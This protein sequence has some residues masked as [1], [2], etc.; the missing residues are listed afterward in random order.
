M[1]LFCGGLL[2]FVVAANS[3]CL[4][5]RNFCDECSGC[6]V[7]H[8]G[9]CD[10]CGPRPIPNGPLEELRAMHRSL[11]CGGGCGEVYYGE[12]F[13]TPPNCCDPCDDSQ[14]WVGGDGC[15]CLPFVR[16]RGFLSGLLG[17]RYR[18][19]DTPGL[20][21][22]TCGICEIC[23]GEDSSAG[24][25]FAG[26]SPGDC[27]WCGTEGADSATARAVDRIRQGTPLGPH[28]QTAQRPT[29][30]TPPISVRR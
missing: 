9:G 3:G 17:Q 27:D 1:K 30:S 15:K 10:D 13:S 11:I 25:G 18:C 8:C 20:L 23:C 28:N 16:F 7:D 4:M 19:D 29:I 21:D 6:A 5:T 24:D 14:Q 2:L 12:W 22:C 26:G